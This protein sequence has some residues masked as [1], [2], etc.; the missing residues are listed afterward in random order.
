MAPSASLRDIGLEGFALID[1]FYGAPAAPRRS[2]T[3]GVF[4]AR[5]GRWVVQV[6]HD[7]L[8]EPA[9]N[10]KEVAARFGGVMAV[11]YFK[12]KPQLRCG[13]RK[14]LGDVQIIYQGSSEAGS[15]GLYVPVSLV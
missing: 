3:K 7:E 6:P 1:R 14:K 4:P 15:L 13:F 10:S 2:H 11:T 5:K 8:E 9:M 12:G